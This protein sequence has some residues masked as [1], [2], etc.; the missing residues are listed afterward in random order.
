MCG[1][2]HR[3]NNPSY[4]QKQC[5]KHQIPLSLRAAWWA[6]PGPKDPVNNF[7][8]ETHKASEGCLVRLSR[9]MISAPRLSQEGLGCSNHIVPTTH[10]TTFHRKAHKCLFSLEAR[11]TIVS[12][13][14]GISYRHTQS[15]SRANSGCGGMSCC[16]SPRRVVQVFWVGNPH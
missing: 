15:I 5:L 4:T 6:G 1:V 2:N 7:H 16:T 13:A 10:P 12:P 14:V 9:S 11:W 8:T 3:L